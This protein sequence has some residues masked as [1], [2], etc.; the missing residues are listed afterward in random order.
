MII[1]VIS[2]VHG[3]YRALNSVIEDIKKKNVQTIMRNYD[4]ALIHT[5][6]SIRL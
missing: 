2:D 4:E 1:A 5:G 3:N 6:H